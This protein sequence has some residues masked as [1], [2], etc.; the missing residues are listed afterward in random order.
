MKTISAVMANPTLIRD[1]GVF[2]GLSAEVR[3]IMA[4]DGQEIAF[5]ICAGLLA[6]LRI[7]HSAMDGYL[8]SLER[9]RVQPPMT[10]YWNDVIQDGPNRG[11]PNWHTFSPWYHLWR[12]AKSD[13]SQS[14]EIWRTNTA[15]ARPR[16]D[17]ELDGLYATTLQED[18]P[19]KPI[20]R[21]L[22]ERAHKRNA[23]AGEHGAPVTLLDFGCGW[24]Q[25]C[26]F[27]VAG[28]GYGIAPSNLFGCD[29]LPA[30]VDAA[31]RL[32]GGRIGVP[33]DHFFQADALTWQPSEFVAKHGSPT[34]V[35]L[36]EVSCTLG[37]ADWAVA[38]GKI[39]ALSPRY[40]FESHSLRSWHLIVGRDDSNA[41]WNA[42]GYSL[43]SETLPGE[44]LTQSNLAELVLV[45]K[46][47][48]CARLAVYER[49]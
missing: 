32:C 7:P 28:I 3:E 22:I 42:L 38:A 45:R 17:A 13:P 33:A 24:G 34:I 20:L 25:W 8:T 44:R 23:D 43:I 41:L 40:V 31:R 9:V 18:K 30:R 39:A 16:A 6:R 15:I 5:A 29:F 36:M 49:S 19:E 48:H 11:H 14:Q 4:R 46:Y 21:N 12:A 35:T 47:W 26:K 10:D 1:A 2:Y 27:V 37:D